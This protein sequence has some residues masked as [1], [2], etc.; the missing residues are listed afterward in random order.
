MT[1]LSTDEDE[2]L[3]STNNKSFWRGQ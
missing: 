1:G 3:N 2:E